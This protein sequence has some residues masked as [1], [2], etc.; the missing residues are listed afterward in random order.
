MTQEERRY[1]RSMFN[2]RTRLMGQLNQAWGERIDALPKR[3][4]P[5]RLKQETPWISEVVHTC[6]AILRT[7]AEED[8]VL[9][10]SDRVVWAVTSGKPVPEDVRQAAMDFNKEWDFI[11]FQLRPAAINWATRLDELIGVD[12][13]LEKVV[14]QWGKRLGESQKV[15]RTG[16]GI[17]AL[18]L[19]LP[20]RCPRP[21]KGTLIIL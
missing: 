11:F 16:R 3:P 20:S 19:C 14:Q 5:Q 12:R 18:F 13:E 15:A 21:N 10:T 2:S 9:A 4:D 7:L 8:G 17:P 1:L 6:S